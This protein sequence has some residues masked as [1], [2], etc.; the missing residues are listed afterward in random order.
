M[1]RH[2][3]QFCFIAMSIAL[4]TA[5]TSAPV[6]QAGS[7][8][9]Y[10]DYSHAESGYVDTDHKCD[11]LGMG[12][13]IFEMLGVTTPRFAEGESVSRC[14]YFVAPGEEAQLHGYVVLDVKP[15]N[16]ENYEDHVLDMLTAGASVTVNPPVGDQASLMTM[17]VES[18]R[19]TTLIATSGQDGYDIVVTVPMSIDISDDTIFSM[20]ETLLGQ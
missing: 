18:L 17:D 6:S 13:Y 1:P 19:L 8:S 2:K 20:M 4:V 15:W 16:A 12:K 7:E 9:Q 14:L 11:S 5:C 10:F 3:V